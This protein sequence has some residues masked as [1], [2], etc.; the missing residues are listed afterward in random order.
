MVTAYI[1]ESYT[2]DRYFIGAAFVPDAAVTTLGQAFD[3][4]VETTAQL[5]GTPVPAELHGY[6]IMSGS[7]DWELLRG[8][9]REAAGL[10]LA[11]L[12]AAREAGVKYLFRGVDVA[13]LN[14]RYRY[15][16][17][18]HTIVLGHLL[19]R[20]DDYAITTGQADPVRIVADEIATQEAHRSEFESYQRAGTPGYRSSTLDMIDA[21]ITF[22]R[23]CDEPGLQAA[24]L[25][26]YVHRRRHTVTSTG[27]AA[28]TLRRLCAQIDPSTVHD[29]TWVP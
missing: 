20:I 6:E 19:E 22:A 27:K 28:Q 2:A 7:G 18:P 4:I 16:D 13:R 21:Q 24:D 12:R 25:A 10:Y 29:W 23:S 9:H 26:V 14:A 1:D 3:Q 5:H 17:R 11:A 15:P 8:K